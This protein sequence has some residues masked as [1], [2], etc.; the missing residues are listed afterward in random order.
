MPC[1][2]GAAPPDPSAPPFPGYAWKNKV[3]DDEDDGG[4]DSN[5]DGDDDG[6]GDGDGDGDDDDDLRQILGSR[7]VPIQRPCH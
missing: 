2:P 7:R 5:D 1:C 6:D 4:G 3:P